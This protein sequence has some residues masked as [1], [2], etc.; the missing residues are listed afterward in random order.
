M[1]DLHLGTWVKS[2]GNESVE[3]M[4]AAGFDFV[5]IDLEHAFPTVYPHIVTAAGRG[6]APLVRVPDHGASMIQRVLD[7]GAAGVLVPHVDDAAQAAAV[8]AAVRFPPHGTRGSG[9]TSRAAQWGL[10]DRAEYQRFGNSEALCIAQLESR[11]AMANAA[12]IL[13]VPGVSA[14][15]VGAADLALDTGLSANDPELQG[16]VDAALAA[17]QAAGKP[18][19]WAVGSNPAA[20]RKAFERG[21]DFVVMGNDLSML[22]ETAHSLVADVG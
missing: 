19:G 11:T 18:I 13:A 21:F 22:A 7:A 8:A 2:S 1:P 14:G 17:S 15:F 20:A 5:V 3:I 4:A 16:M 12:E 9:G 6:V 10:L